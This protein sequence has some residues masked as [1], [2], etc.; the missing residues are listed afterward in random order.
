MKTK[1]THSLIAMY[2]NVILATSTEGYI[3]VLFLVFAIISFILYILSNNYS[4][5]K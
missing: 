5:N 2:G 1:N 4:K 3:S